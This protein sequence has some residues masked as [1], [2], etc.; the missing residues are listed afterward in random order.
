[1]KCL[2]RFFGC[3][4]DRA[5]GCE[6]T[7]K[8]EKKKEERGKKNPGPDGKGEETGKH[9]PCEEEEGNPCQWHGEDFTLDCDV[10]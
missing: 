6:E 7:K 8:E 5:A 3:T 9:D 10:V 2:L 4:Q 1:M